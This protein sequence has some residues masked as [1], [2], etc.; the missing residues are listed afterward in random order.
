MKEGMP[1][2]GLTVTEPAKK[3]GPGRPPRAATAMR[4]PIAAASEDRVRPDIRG[5]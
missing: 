4:P 3:R 2:E 1:I 5:G